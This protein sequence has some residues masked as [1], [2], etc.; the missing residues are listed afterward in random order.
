MKKLLMMIAV[1]AVA[2]CAQ[3]DR[4]T[5]TASGR[6]EAMFN[7]TTPE[8]VSGKIANGCATVGKTVV[9]MTDNQVICETIM[10]LGD[11]FITE[12]AIGNAYST[13][14]RRFSR[15]TIF[16]AGG[17]MVR[18]QLYQWVETQMAFGQTRAMEF[19]SN[20]AF[21]AAMGFLRS[22]GGK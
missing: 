18:V 16:P 1:V 11:T 22:I 17:G 3:P 6:P 7:N 4:I 13:P 14:P 9:N 12:L 10:G 21:N 5:E 20:Q 8:A 15:F 2:G 19:N